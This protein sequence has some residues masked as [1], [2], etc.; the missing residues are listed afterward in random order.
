LHLY[1]NKNLPTNRGIYAVEKGQFIGEFFVYIKTLDNGEFSFLSLPKMN[2]RNVTSE[3]FN[4]GLKNKIIVFIEKLP[5]PIYRLCCQQYN[6][7]VDKQK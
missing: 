7:S 5:K 6:K 1:F 3:S 4:T 2:K